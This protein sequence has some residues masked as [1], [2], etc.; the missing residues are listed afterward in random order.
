M[1]SI[2]KNLTQNNKNLIFSALSIF[3]NICVGLFY[4]P[5]LIKNLGILAYGIIPLALLINQY[6]GVFTESLTSVFTRY[7]TIAIQKN[8]WIEASK[9]ISISLFVVIILS[10]VLIYPFYFLIDNLTY[11]FN[12]P[13]KYVDSAK[14]LFVLTIVSFTISLY[15]SLFNT[16]LFAYNKIDY[17]NII[18]I[19]RGVLKP[20]IIFLSFNYIYTDI[21]FIGIANLIGEFI[22]LIF[23]YYIFKK[24]TNNKIVFNLLRLNKIDVFSMLAIVFWILIQNLGD[25]GLFKSDIFILNY[26]WSTKE[27]GVVGALNE[28]INYIY[29][30]G[31]TFS[32]LFFPTLI[33]YYSLEKHSEFANLIINKSVLFGVS[34]AVIIGTILGFSNIIL[35][36]WFGD[37]VY[38]NY[39]FWTILKFCIV[40]FYISSVFFTFASRTW[41]KVK[42]PAILTIF[43]GLINLGITFLIGYVYRQ[44]EFINLILI[45]NL[46]FGIFQ[47]YFINGYFFY[48]LYPNMLKKIALNFITIS[49]ILIISLIISHLFFLTVD[50]YSF[51]IK[52]LSFIIVN[53]LLFIS[54]IVFLVPHYEIKKILLIIKRKL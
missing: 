49:S 50:K 10:L 16:V 39:K 45:V 42:Y 35:P 1:T 43:I 48:R 31:F 32:G 30:I 51:L 20:F 33:K 5:Y 6:L 12:I 9:H 25:I 21:I 36:L 18:K 7:Y 11:I 41:N 46:F 44:H 23:S 3:L 4:T 15:S 47:C 14:Y 37:I 17:L 24:F 34:S 26:F 27:S 54:V 29:I 53:I 52:F 19:I 38:I 13:F 28:I 8:D 2:V 22:I 40:P